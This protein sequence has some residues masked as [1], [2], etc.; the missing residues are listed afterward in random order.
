VSAD[1][2]GSFFI[3]TVDNI[4]IQE[5]VTDEVQVFAG[6]RKLSDAGNGT[7]LE[8]SAAADSNDGAFF[9]R[10][11]SGGLANYQFASRGTSVASLAAFVFTSPITNVVTSTSDISADNITIRANGAQVATSSTDQ[12]TGSF[13]AY[14]LYIGAR[15]GSSLFFRGR[16][17]GII[18]RFGPNLSNT[19]ILDTEE[20]LGN[21]TG[22]L[23]VLWNGVWQDQYTWVDNLNW[24]DGV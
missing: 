5:L 20:W 3:G 2:G 21:K 9:F 4:S 12:G 24:N 17:Y 16:D 8:T 11:P 23:Y 1:F 18:V 7:L 19:T 15:G 10:A 13:G 14:P 22:V 6:V